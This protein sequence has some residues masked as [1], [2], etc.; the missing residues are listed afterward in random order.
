MGDLF[1]TGALKEDGSACED[2]GYK[3]IRAGGN[4]PE[5]LKLQK[6][7]DDDDSDRIKKLASRLEKRRYAAYI[8]CTT[9]GRKWEGI[10]YDPVLRT[11]YTALSSIERGMEKSE[12][13]YDGKSKTFTPVDHIQLKKNSCGCVYEMGF[14]GPDSYSISWMKS[15]VCG[16]KNESHPLAADNACSVDGIASPDNVA[17]IP[18]HGQ[19]LIGEDT[20]K[21]QNDMVW[22]RDASN[23]EMTRVATTPYGSETTSPY[24][25]P[26]INGH[27][28]ITL[29]VQ[30]PYGESDEEK[31][32]DMESTGEA[33]WVGYMGPLSKVKKVE[34]GASATAASLAL[35]GLM[36]AAVALV[37]Y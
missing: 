14:N 10:T 6:G 30:H 18:E 5:C 26:N 11:M 19:L 21:H 35:T 12:A 34:A 20:G 7:F 3:I 29:V 37:A 2:E 27:S 4:K 16:F 15:L 32:S 24:W 25:Y 33:G 17:S 9:E 1:K 31:V 36:A 28:Y 23:G 22:V 8:G 13:K